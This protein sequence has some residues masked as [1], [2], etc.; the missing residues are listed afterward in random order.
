MVHAIK[1][2]MKWLSYEKYKHNF[3]FIYNK[4]D[5]VSDCEK[6]ENLL[7]MCS[8]LGADPSQEF[9]VPSGY[10]SSKRAIKMAQALGF[11]P[12]A[13]YSEVKDDLRSLKDAVFSYDTEIQ[14]KFIPVVKGVC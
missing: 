11:A 7:S 14:R 5:N 13:E 12:G 10:D 4:S 8:L 2:M 3:V 9:I 1:K 6:E